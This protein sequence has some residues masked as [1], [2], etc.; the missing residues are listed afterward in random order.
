MGK[1]FSR[2]NQAE[3]F[4]QSKNLTGFEKSVFSKKN[5]DWEGG[6]VEIQNNPLLKGGVRVIGGG[7]SRKTAQIAMCV[8]FSMWKLACVVMYICACACE[9]ECETWNINLFTRGACV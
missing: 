9:F 6:G 5:H 3:T 4:L 1:K 2:A 7:G 8:S